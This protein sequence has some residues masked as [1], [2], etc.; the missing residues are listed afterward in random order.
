MTVDGLLVSTRRL[1]AAN[2]AT[3][4]VSGPSACALACCL[5]SVGG[6][7]LLTVAFGTWTA[8]SAWSFPRFLLALLVLVYLPG[9]FLIQTAAL[10]L[11]L[12]ENLTLSLVLG[13]TVGSVVY[14]VAGTLRIPGLFLVWPCG[15]SIIFLYRAQQAWRNTQRN[16]GLTKKKVGI[17][18]DDSHVWLTAV[19]LLAWGLLVVV[20]FYYQKS[21]RSLPGERHVHRQVGGLPW[22]SFLHAV[23][24]E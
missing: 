7:V 4:T 22:M 10:R 2:A 12:L 15:A 19:I 17:A 14:Y 1:P 23:S 16:G 9:R 8:T 21:G 3:R 13:M 24:G 18:L 6:L 5:M 20:P 11:A